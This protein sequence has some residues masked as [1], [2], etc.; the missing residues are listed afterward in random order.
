MQTLLDKYLQ[1]L[2]DKY[3]NFQTLLMV[4]GLIDARWLC[5]RNNGFFS[6]CDVIAGCLEP[7]DT[8]VDPRKGGYRTQ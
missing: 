6:L 2:L 4:M 1:T 7:T 8:F 3:L 5:N